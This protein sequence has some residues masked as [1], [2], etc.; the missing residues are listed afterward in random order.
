MNITEIVPRD[1]A[2][3][4]IRTEDGQMGLFDVK[5]Y[6]ESEAF[7]PL[8]DKREFQR[9]HNGKYFIVWDCGADLS[10]DT[11]LSRMALDS[12]NVFS[13][14]ANQSAANQSSNSDESSFTGEKSYDVS[15][16][17]REFGQAYAPWSKEDDAYLGKRFLEGATISDLVSEFGRQPGAIRS[18]VRKLGLG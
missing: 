11:I 2:V 10:A 14:A 16:I 12:S 6:L 8:K 17:R 4:Q 15:T 9:V 7:A 13:G 5:P 3:L 18:R 1:N